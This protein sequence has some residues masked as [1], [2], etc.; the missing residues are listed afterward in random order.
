[1]GLKTADLADG[2]YSF[3]GFP[4]MLNSLVVKKAIAKGVQDRFFGYNIG[5]RKFD[6]RLLRAWQQS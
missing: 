5:T 1:M 6:G 3:L 2:F 4:R